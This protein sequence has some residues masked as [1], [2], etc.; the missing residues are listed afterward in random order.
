M[1]NRS[2]SNVPSSCRNF[3]RLMLDRLQAVSS[4]NMYSQHGFDALIRPLF[5]QVCQRVDRGVVLHARVAAVPGAFG[6]L[7]HQVAGLV[8]R[9]RRGRVGDPAASPT[10]RRARTAC[11]NSSVRRTERFAFW[12]MIEL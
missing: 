1:R 9:A 10:A 7:P 11:M 8:A 3:F 5:G 4:R 6:H 12:N 2:T